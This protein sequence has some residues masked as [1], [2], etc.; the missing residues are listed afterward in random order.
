MATYNYASTINP[1]DYIFSDLNARLPN[2]APQDYTIVTDR[3][4]ILQSIWRLIKTK[5][6]EIPN[7]RGYGLDLDQFIQRPM[8]QMLA[9]NIDE[10]V[11]GKIE[12]Y[13]PRVE[14]Y[15]SQ[16]L[17]DYINSQV[18]LQYYLKIKSTEEI[19]ALEPITVP[20]G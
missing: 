10:Y 9:S 19:I 6:G 13:E 4:A 1:N 3:E 18:I 7:Y 16:V 17:P 5:E 11:S 14:V 20:I 12:Q 2:V 15:K 8:N